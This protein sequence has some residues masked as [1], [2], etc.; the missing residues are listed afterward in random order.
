MFYTI[1]TTLTKYMICSVF[2]LAG[3]FSMESLHALGGREGSSNEETRSEGDH[4]SERDHNNSEGKHE[5]EVVQGPVNVL[6]VSQGRRADRE[7]AGHF[8]DWSREYDI[9]YSGLRIQDIADD[10]DISAYDAVI[11]LSTQ[12]S[13]G[14]DPELLEFVEQFKN[15]VRM[16]FIG[17]IPRSNSTDY[18]IDTAEVSDLGVDVVTAST[19]W[20]GRTL[21]EMHKAWFREIVALLSSR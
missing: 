16:T 15:D 17:L 4:D 21:R 3:L 9:R 13:N 7:A 18:T 12:D 2:V 19:R 6:V 10:F 11:V 5:S 1:F 14:R 20:G 8:P